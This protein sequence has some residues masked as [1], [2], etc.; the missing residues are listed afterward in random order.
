VNFGVTSKLIATAFGLCGF[1]VA[2]IAGLG[3]GNSAS[4]VLAT[5]LV[6]MV[7]CQLTGLAAG[8]VGQHVI[9]EHLDAYR[10]KNPLPTLGEEAGNNPSS[11]P[12]E[13]NS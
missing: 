7:V 1:A 12:I 8:A 3:A 5:A 10:K 13:Q 4:K 9:S 2:I 11:P 6:C